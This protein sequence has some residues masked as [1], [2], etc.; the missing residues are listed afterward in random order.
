ML[1]TRFAMLCCTAAGVS[2]ENIFKMK[3]SYVINYEIMSKHMIWFYEFNFK[4]FNK[5]WCNEGL[6]F[7]FNLFMNN[8]VYELFFMLKNILKAQATKL[9]KCFMKPFHHDRTYTHHLI[10]ERQPMLMSN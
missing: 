6:V 7:H 10:F 2:P 8:F 1:F 9:F 3:I 4:M 5:I